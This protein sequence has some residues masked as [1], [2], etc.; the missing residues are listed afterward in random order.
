MSDNLELHLKHRPVIFKQ[1]LG[2]TE[3]VK[4]LHEMV[5]NNR[6]PHAIILQ[7]GPGTGKTTTARILKTKL[8]CGDFDF[9]EI[10]A[11]E[12]RGIDTI[13][14]IKARMNSAPMEGECRI[15]LL[16]E[17]HKLTNDSQ[18]SLLK[19]LEDTPRHVYF[20]LATTDPGKLLPTILSRCTRI[21]FKPLSVAD[22]K[23]LVTSIAVKET[24]ELSDAL[25]D[26]IAEVADGSARVAVKLL[27]QVMGLPT[28]AERIEAVQRSDSKRQAIDI[29]RK[30]IDRRA[31][32][33]E[34]A[35]IIKEVEEEPETIRR[36]ILGYA[37]AVLLNGNARGYQ[38]ICCFEG[39]LYDS[40]KAGLVR[41]AYE[42]MNMK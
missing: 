30:L 3:V 12:S 8:K 19:L 34:I 28:D 23:T 33:Q 9:E 14:S 15:F 24:L 37:S 13:R 1:L 20:I 26:K 41:A 10:N 22:L 29:A 11:A 36:I 40:G 31:S 38:I 39:N 21:T 16:D 32:W 42:A 17:S 5:T 25:V 18:N 35:K 6:V 7:G 2:Q 4:T 27:N